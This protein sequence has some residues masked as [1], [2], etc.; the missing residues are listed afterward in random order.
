MMRLHKYEIFRI[1]HDREI[2]GA[3]AAVIVL[4]ILMACLGRRTLVGWPIEIITPLALSNP[5][6]SMWSGVVLAPVF[7][8]LEFHNR[9][10]NIA[11]CSGYS[12]SKILLVKAFWYYLIA[13]VVLAVSL[14]STIWISYGRISYLINGFGEKL[15]LL[16]L[17]NCATLTIPMVVTFAFGDIFSSF[18]TNA[19][20]TYAVQ[21]LMEN[22]T[23]SNVLSYYPPSIQ[24]DYALW[25]KLP[26]AL[27]SAL[28]CVLYIIVG[29]TVCIFTLKYRE[30]K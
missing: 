3:L 24:V 30:L 18:A 19:I 28:I 27:T 6:L 10:L 5:L 22:G 15:A 8:G 7:F 14:V 21:K 11:V 17:I 20:F 2:W 1:S 13:V 26:G 25:N 23:L 16:T 12:R 29:L 4:S 9:T